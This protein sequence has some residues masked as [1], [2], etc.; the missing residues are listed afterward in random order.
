VIATS[1]DMVSVYY[2]ASM[3]Q[4]IELSVTLRSATDTFREQ[5]CM[6]LLNLLADFVECSVGGDFYVFRRALAKVLLA[7]KRSSEIRGSSLS[8]ELDR[9]HKHQKTTSRLEWMFALDAKLWKQPKMALRR[10]LMAINATSQEYRISMSEF[11]P[12]RH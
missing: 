12:R 9:L 3:L 1:D 7:P 10:I 11:T 6:T 8:P 2:T 5:A 4:Q